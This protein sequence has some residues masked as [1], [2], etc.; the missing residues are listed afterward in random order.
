[1]E[2]RNGD[3]SVVAR[4]GW[5][6]SSFSGSNG[7]Q[8][9]EVR[10]DGDAVHIRDSKYRRNPA[11]ELAAEPV[12]TVTPEQWLPF[13]AVAA[14]QAHSFVEPAIDADAYGVT[15]RGENGVALRYT[16]GEWDAFVAGVRAGEFDYRLHAA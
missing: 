12:I 11:A 13:V 10:F 7:G 4:G 6:K 2:A 9:V 3:V 8:C 5:R 16:L 1:M 15:L 14:G